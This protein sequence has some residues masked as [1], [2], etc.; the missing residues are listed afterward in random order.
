MLLVGTLSN[1]LGACLFQIFGQSQLALQLHHLGSHG[2]NFMFN[3]LGFHER[4]LC[5]HERE[6]LL[7][8]D[9]QFLRSDGQR[10]VSVLLL[11]SIN[12]AS[13]FLAGYSLQALD[14]GVYLIVKVCPGCLEPIQVFGEE[15]CD[16]L[17]IPNYPG[18]IGINVVELGLDDGDGGP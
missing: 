10:S 12:V 14:Q 5:L 4:P 11:L 3:H 6:L 18:G 9:G 8:H 16:L 7:G 17:H 15:L 1:L 13:E 2:H